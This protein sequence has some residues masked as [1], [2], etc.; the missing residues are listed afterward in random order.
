MT[1]LPV[2]KERAP[3]Y[4]SYIEIFGRDCF[5]DTASHGRKGAD[6]FRAEGWSLKYLGFP[7]GVQLLWHDLV[8]LRRSIDA[9]RFCVRR[10]R[11]S[12]PLLRQQRP[13][14]SQCL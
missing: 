1:A 2:P 12:E 7:K 8:Q 10:D 6:S 14:P 9:K 3:L 11:Q 5:G 13:V 4:H